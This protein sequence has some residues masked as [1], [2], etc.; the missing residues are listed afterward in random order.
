MEEEKRRREGKGNGIRE[1]EKRRK[2]ERK[3]GGEIEESLRGEMRNK[4]KKKKK[5][6]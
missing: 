2:G 1:R 6:K 4:E 5:H 3:E